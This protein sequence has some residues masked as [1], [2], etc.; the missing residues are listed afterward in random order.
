[1]I[2]R[3]LKKNDINVIKVL[4]IEVLLIIYKDRFE[5]LIYNL[6]AVNNKRQSLFLSQP[7]HAMV[8]SFFYHLK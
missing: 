2:K 3:S 4:Q 8:H 1:M 7:I 5:K 6:I